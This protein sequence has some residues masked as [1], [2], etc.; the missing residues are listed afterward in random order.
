MSTT[1][2]IPA[3]EIPAAETPLAE[4]LPEF[5]VVPAESLPE[6]VSAA[7]TVEVTR[8]SQRNEWRQEWN[9]QTQLGRIILSIRLFMAISNLILTL[10]LISIH[11]NTINHPIIIMF[12]SQKIAP[13][14]YPLPQAILP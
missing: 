8:Q 10:T 14:P 4:T 3:A 6:A 7:E 2:P 12:L 13:S 11:A 1:I 5:I 9:Q